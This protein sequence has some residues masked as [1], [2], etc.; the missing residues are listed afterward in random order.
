MSGAA[1]AQEVTRL[2]RDLS[3][4]DPSA[5]ERLVPL[6][7]GE[8]RE[9]ATREMRKERGEHTLQATALVHEVVLRFLGAT[10]LSWQSRAHFMHIAAQAMRRILVDHARARRAEKRGG[11][12]VRVTLDEQLRAPDGQVADAVDIDDALRRLATLDE[13]KARVVELR[14]FAGLSVEDTARVL[15]VSEPTVKREWRFARAW[16]QRALSD[17]EHD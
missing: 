14:V 4:G 17:A 7:Y 15:G 6:V 13:R 5:L 8:L 16:L 11:D 1:P 2:L 12:L 3:G 9:I 10:D